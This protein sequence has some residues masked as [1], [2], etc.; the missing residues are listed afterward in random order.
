VSAVAGCLGL[1]PNWQFLLLL[2]LL[3]LQLLSDCALN[4]WLH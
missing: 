1:L 3:L 2:L 4:S